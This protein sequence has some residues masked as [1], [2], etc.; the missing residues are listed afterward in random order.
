MSDT[1]SRFRPV[2]RQLTDDEKQLIDQIKA[3]AAELE[4]L[5]KVIPAGRYT[6][7]AMTGLEESVMWAVKALTS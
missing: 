1:P 6:S 4:S 5:F 7:L 3:K 2:H